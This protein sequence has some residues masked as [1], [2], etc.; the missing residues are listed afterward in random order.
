MQGKK[1]LWT[2]LAEKSEDIHVKAPIG[3]AIEYSEPE[4]AEA[5]LDKGADVTAHD[6]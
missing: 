5:L 1:P 2:V 6:S 3:N 4:L